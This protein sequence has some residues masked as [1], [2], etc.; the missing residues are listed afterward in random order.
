MCFLEVWVRGKHQIS[1][2]GLKL[3]KTLGTQR[4][5]YLPYFQFHTYLSSLL[6]HQ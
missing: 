1:L 5:D 6:V 3:K 4:L 2:L